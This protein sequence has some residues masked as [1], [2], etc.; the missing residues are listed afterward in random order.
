MGNTHNEGKQRKRGRT[1]GIKEEH[2]ETGREKGQK[3]VKYTELPPKKI[4]KKVNRMKVRNGRRKGRREGE[5]E[6]RGIR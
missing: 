2:E 1:N 3:A 5:R 6:G 4:H